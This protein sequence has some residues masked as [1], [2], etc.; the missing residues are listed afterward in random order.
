MSVD[1]EFSDEYICGYTTYD[2]AP[3]KRI[4]SID[5]YDQDQ[6]IPSDHSSS[7][8]GTYHSLFN[9][10]IFVTE[11]KSICSVCN[12]SRGVGFNRC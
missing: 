8:L 2:L 5:Y 1:C 4:R 6:K 7:S 9:L 12:P 10:C 3:W 11:E